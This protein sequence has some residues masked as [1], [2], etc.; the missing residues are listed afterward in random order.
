M[1]L[2]TWRRWDR[3]EDS[4]ADAGLGGAAASHQAG[5]RSQTKLKL[6]AAGQAVRLDPVA[7]SLSARA[8]RLPWPHPFL[9]PRGRR[10]LRDRLELLQLVRREKRP[11][12]GPRLDSRDAPV[13]LQ[14][15]NLL[16]LGLDGGEVPLVLVEER[17]QGDLRC[18]DVHAPRNGFSLES[19][20]QGLEFLNLVRGEP[21]LLAVGQDDGDERHSRGVA[22]SWT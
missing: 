11:P 2:T 10:P 22:Y 1:H 20:P 6:T 17:V 9:A 3:P 5:V 14:G 16:H 12:G 7:W 8:I 4:S 13:S 19:G 15:S 21:Q 18:P